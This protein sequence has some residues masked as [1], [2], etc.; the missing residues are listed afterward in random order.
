MIQT[1]EIAAQVAAAAQ[2]LLQAGAVQTGQVLVVGCSTS[3]VLGDKIGTGGS[4]EAAG[5]MFAALRRVTE[6]QGVF[7]G[8]P[9]LRAFEPGS[10][11]YSGCCRKIRLAG[12]NCAACAPCG[13]CYG[14]G[15]LRKF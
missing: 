1:A 3:E 12:S 15:G 2:E 14:S 4:A 9:V 8:D 7:F 11:H 13:R 6:A 10:G 5:A